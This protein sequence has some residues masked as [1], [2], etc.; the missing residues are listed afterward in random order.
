MLL[1]FSPPVGARRRGRG[2]PIQ[3]KLREDFREL[4]PG[5]AFYLRRGVKMRHFAAVRGDQTFGVDQTPGLFGAVKL[6]Q[7]LLE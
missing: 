2:L 6:A 7:G 3:A 4:P 5:L 1:F